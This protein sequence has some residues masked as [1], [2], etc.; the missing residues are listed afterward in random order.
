[1]FTGIVEATG[2][3][4]TLQPELDNLH[5]TIACP[6]ASELK[7]DQSVAHNGVCLTVVTAD[8][9]QYTVTAISETLRKSN[10]GLLQQD[11]FVNLERSM[12]FNGRIDGHI[13]QG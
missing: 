5:I 13:V 8:A 12:V 11:D 6:F 9:K 2:T 4:I 7:P 1:M 10:L 3:V